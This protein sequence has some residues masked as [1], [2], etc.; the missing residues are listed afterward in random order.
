M[1]RCLR[2]KRGCPHKG[3]RLYISGGIT[4]DPNYREKFRNAEIAARRYGFR[5]VNPAKAGDG[6]PW[7]WYMKRD[8]RLLLKCDAI[9]MLPDWCGSRGARLERRIASDLGLKLYNM[10]YA[11]GERMI[12]EGSY[13]TFEKEGDGE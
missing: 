5:P 13:V 9:L 6:K 4:G 12:T 3:K 10:V 8:I 2:A 1:N 11:M 7:E